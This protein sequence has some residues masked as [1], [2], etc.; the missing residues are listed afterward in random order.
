MK[1]IET[2]QTTDTQGELTLQEPVIVLH[3]HTETLLTKITTCH[4]SKMIGRQV[5]GCRRLDSGMAPAEECVED[6]R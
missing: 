1:M 2:A 5:L 3:C 4:Y 6:C